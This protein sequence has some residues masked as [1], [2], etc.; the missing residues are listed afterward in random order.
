MFN[1]E[2]GVSIY[3]AV[4]I[5]A[6]LLAIVL[7]LNAILVGQI[8]IIRNM[9]YS[10]VAFYAAETGI[11]AAL[12]DPSCETTCELHADLDLGGGNISHYDVYGLSPGSN[13]QG[14]CSGIY[15]CLQSMGTFE[16]TRRAIQVSR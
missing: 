11:E 12:Y 14:N 5:M 1:T 10:V 7:G 6:I 8:K 3:L 9:G 13:P 15:Y 16:Q 4:M 2:K